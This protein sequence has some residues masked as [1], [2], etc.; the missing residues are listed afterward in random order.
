MD[1]LN[2]Q[3]ISTL[4]LPPAGPLL[5]GLI[6]L[7]L[8]A[9]AFGRKLVVIALLLQITLSLPITGE[10]IFSTLQKHPPLSRQQIQDNQAQAIVVL[11][12]GRY[13][14]APEYGSDTASLRLLSR[15]RYAANI[16]RETGLPIIPSGG[17]PGG[18][19][20]SEAE[21]SAKI[22]LLDYGISVRH[23]DKRSRN[24]WENARNIAQLIDGL[25]IKKVILITDAAHM[26]RA[27]DAFKRHGVQL[28]PAPINFEYQLQGERPNYERFI[29]SM[30][31]AMNISLGLHELLGQFWYSLK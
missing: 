18:K 21:I 31:A 26:P 10:L 17:K 2:T 23:M 30:T 24:T 1:S 8:W 14:E 6:G 22:L 20:D 12:G 15:L 7:L 27:A 13:R 29:P 16:A 9:T 11:G 25:D 19:G 28:I 3:L 4:I 5:L